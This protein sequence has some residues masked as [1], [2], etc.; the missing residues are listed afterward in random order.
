MTNPLVTLRSNSAVNGL[1]VKKVGILLLFGFVALWLVYYDLEDSVGY[2]W[3]FCAL[4]IMAIS[5]LFLVAFGQ[6]LSGLPKYTIA[7]NNDECVIYHP[8]GNIRLDWANIQRVDEVTVTRLMQR[9]PIG[10]VGIKLKCAEHLYDTIPL[11]LA[12]RLMIEQ[13]DLH[14]ISAKQQCQL[15]HCEMESIVDQLDNLLVMSA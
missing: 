6:V 8:K 15:G 9:Q 14:I 13:K 10:Y 4:V 2:L 1:Q 11:R 7:M 5:G 3:L 12:S